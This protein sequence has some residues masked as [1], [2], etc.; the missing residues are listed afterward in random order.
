MTIT[1]SPGIEHTR[2]EDLGSHAGSRLPEYLGSSLKMRRLEGHVHLDPD[3][4]PDLRP[5]KAS[6]QCA[7]LMLFG[8]CDAAQKH[9]EN[10]G[11]DKGTFSSSLAYSKMRLSKVIRPKF[12]RSSRKRHV[13]WGWL[14]IGQ[15]H[16]IPEGSIPKA[17][18]HAKHH[19][20]LQFRKRA[21]NCIYAGTPALTFRPDLPGAGTFPKFC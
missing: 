7:D 13:I 11:I 6:R 5:K 18:E 19:S 2:F 8:Q 4:R 14:Q 10:Q 3:I 21:N 1:S 15:I 9:L 16:R 17:L 12:V 20:H